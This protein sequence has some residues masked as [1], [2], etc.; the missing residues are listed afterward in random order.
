VSIVQID[1]YWFSAS[2]NGYNTRGNPPCRPLALE[3]GVFKLQ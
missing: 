3:F 2:G 1:G